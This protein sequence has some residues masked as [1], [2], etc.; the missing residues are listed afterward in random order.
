MEDKK[1]P[2]ITK[3]HE[4]QVIFFGYQIDNDNYTNSYI[5]IHFKKENKV[6]KLR[7][8][9]PL[10]LEINKGFN[11]NVCGMEIL[12]ISKFQLDDIGVKVSN[13]EQDAG[14]TFLAKKV[15]E[16]NN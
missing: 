8:F 2:I 12:D 4:Y 9:Q 13:F 14:I 6:I 3:P 16:L 15:V 11:G 5:D 1:H 10:E 7:F